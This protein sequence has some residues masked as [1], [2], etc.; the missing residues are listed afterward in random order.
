MN[1][2]RGSASSV[3]THPIEGQ[4]ICCISRETVQRATSKPL[5][6]EPPPDLAHAVDLEIFLEHAPHLALQGIIRF[7]PGRQSGGIVPL[8]DMVVVGRRG[9]RQHLEDRLDA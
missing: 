2:E 1:G 4:T 7:P 9:D 8:G 3:T 6:L 5:P